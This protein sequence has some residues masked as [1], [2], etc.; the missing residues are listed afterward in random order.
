MFFRPVPGRGPDASDGDSLAY[1]DRLSHNIHNLEALIS[2]RGVQ[3]G[4][5]LYKNAFLGNF[6]DSLAT[7]EAILEGWVADMLLCLVYVPRLAARE[8]RGEKSCKGTWNEPK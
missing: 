2:S 4:L 8:G 6:E 3:N 1:F 5:N 7:E